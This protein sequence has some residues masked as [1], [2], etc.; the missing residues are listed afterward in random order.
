MKI[1]N[2][3]KID[4]FYVL[5]LLKVYLSEY[6]IFFRNLFLKNRKVK[7]GD[8]GVIRILNPDGSTHGSTFVGTQS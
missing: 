5:R 3:K 4:I 6:N 8:L 1:Q 2:K 7:I